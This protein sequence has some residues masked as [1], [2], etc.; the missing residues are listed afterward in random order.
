VFDLCD[1]IYKFKREI[2]SSTILQISISK[3]DQYK[4]FK[5]SNRLEIADGRRQI[6]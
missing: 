6:V 5:N 2:S 3:F 1:T 4:N